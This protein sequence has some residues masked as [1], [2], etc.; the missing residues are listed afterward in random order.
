MD[1]MLQAYDLLEMLILKLAL[2]KLDDEVFDWISAGFAPGQ[3]SLAPAGGCPSVT[4]V[5]G[6]PPPGA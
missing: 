5:S 6:H 1:D 4:S 3:S 2:L